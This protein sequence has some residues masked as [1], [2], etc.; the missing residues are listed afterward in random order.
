MV[1]EERKTASGD[2]G[3]EPGAEDER[4]VRV[5]VAI[6]AAVVVALGVTAALTVPRWRLAGAVAVLAAAVMVPLSRSGIDRRVMDTVGGILGA[7]TNGVLVALTGGSSSVFLPLFGIGPVMG[8]TVPL[9]P[10]QIAVNMVLAVL[11]LLSPYLYE[12]PPFGFPLLVVGHI[13]MWSVAAV[14]VFLVVRRLERQRSRLQEVDQART[15][16]LRAISHELRTPLTLIRGATDVLVAHDT[17]LPV[18]AR[19]ELLG[20][21]HRQAGRLDTLLRDLL[22]VDRLERGAAVVDLVPLRLDAL[23]REL[24]PHLDTNHH[25][26]E[27]GPLA[28]VE[29]AGDRAKLERVVENLVV[30]AVKHTPSGCRIRVSVEQSVSSGLI[31]VEDDGPGVPVALRTAVFR[32][33]VQAPDQA[34]SASPGTGVGLSLVKEF[35]SLHGGEVTLDASGL[36]GG[37]RFTVCLPRRGDDV[38]H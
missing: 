23:V 22:D 12:Q 14:A 31:V 4:R 8:A 30:N 19:R 32:P 35:V 18:D 9:P 24:V 17:E 38:D 33:F 37:A 25:D 5:A 1:A 3:L 7:A 20:A 15:L 11:G 2:E 10:W 27:L 36:L 28:S 34:R 13:A 6:S 26:L 29:I 16:F 21:L